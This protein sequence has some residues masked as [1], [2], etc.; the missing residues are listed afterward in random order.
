VDRGRRAALLANHGAVTIGE[1]IE[2]AADLALQLEWLAEVAYYATL[3]GTPSRLGE[4]QLDAVVEQT[5]A[6][7]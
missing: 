6:L 1:T 7:A 3:A 4:R 5:R 2:A